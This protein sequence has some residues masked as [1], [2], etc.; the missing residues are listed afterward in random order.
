MD[1]PLAA[2][3]RAQVLHIASHPLRLA[4][5]LVAAG[6]RDAAAGRHRLGYP[7]VGATPVVVRRGD[8]LAGSAPM[9]DTRALLSFG[10]RRDGRWIS[11]WH[12]PPE[13]P[14]WLPCPVRALQK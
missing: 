13:C 11:L 5:Y 2:P 10:D 8:V 7:G 12:S 4:G 3:L 6:C 1:V 9:A 14:G